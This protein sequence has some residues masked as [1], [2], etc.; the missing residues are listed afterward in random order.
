VCISLIYAAGEA[1][2]SQR[3]E[4]K[5][6]LIRKVLSKRIGAGDSRLQLVEGTDLLGASSVDGLVD[7]THPN[8]LG[9]QWMAEGLAERLRKVLEL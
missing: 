2:G 3:N 5:R 8:D 9:F 4:D 6:Y 1:N 7:G